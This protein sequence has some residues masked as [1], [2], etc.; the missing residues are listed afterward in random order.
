MEAF[1]FSQV[2]TGQRRTSD[3]LGETAVTV[4]CILCTQKVSVVLVST[5]SGSSHSKSGVYPHFTCDQTEAP[6]TNH[7]S[8]LHKGKARVQSSHCLIPF[9]ASDPGANDLV[10]TSSPTRPQQYH[11][12]GLWVSVWTTCTHPSEKKESD[13]PPATFLNSKLYHF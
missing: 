3:A 8:R 5:T 9:L 2:V 10:K 4:A 13:C 7:M 6:V 1:H 12:D 11:L